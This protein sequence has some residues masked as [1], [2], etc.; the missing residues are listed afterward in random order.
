[1]NENELLKEFK[2]ITSRSGGAGGQHVNKVSTKVELRFHIENSQA[3]K[4]EEKTLITE[5]L[6]NRINNNGYLQ[7][8][9]QTERSQI[10]N[11]ER[12]INK[13]FELISKC[14]I[15][16]KH[17]KASKPTFSSIRK[18]LESKKAL[19]Q[20]KTLRNFKPRNES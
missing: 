5:K 12:C 8:T 6:Q 18:R 9:C 17:R 2:F 16:P 19:S 1:M 3:L 15:K 7:I 11:K 14:L 10:R 20:K 4:N 13:F